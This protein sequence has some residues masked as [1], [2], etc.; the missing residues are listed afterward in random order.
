MIRPLHNG[1]IALANENEGTEHRM[2]EKHRKSRGAKQL[3]IEEAGQSLVLAIG[4][5]A[6]T[7]L[8]ISVVMGAS[9]VNLKAR[10]LLA[11]A[12]GAVVA[13]VDEFE[14]VADE[15]SP[16]IQLTT[17]QVSQGVR[18]YLAD[19]GASGRIDNLEI[20]SV[21]IL[22]GGQ[23]AELTLKGTVSPPIVGWVVPSGITIEV[24]SSAQT[25]LSR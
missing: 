16:R 11:I 9:A 14:F 10:Q 2:G 18:R 12:D 17:D 20:G 15:G 22:P 8:T 25:V 21:R 24:S 13:A 23:G 6:L 4:L 3:L 5:C 7:L 19:I 1:L